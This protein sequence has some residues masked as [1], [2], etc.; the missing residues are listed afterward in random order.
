M[1][2]H[3]YRDGWGAEIALPVPPGATALQSHT[4]ASKRNSPDGLAQMG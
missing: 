1:F 2:P 4:A 3:A